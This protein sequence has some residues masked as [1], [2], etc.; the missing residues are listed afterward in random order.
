MGHISCNLLIAAVFIV[1]MFIKWIHNKY[2]FVLQIYLY[3]FKELEL[4]VSFQ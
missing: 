3:I 1:N 2:T 4:L